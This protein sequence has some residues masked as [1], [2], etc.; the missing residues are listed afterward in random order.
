MKAKLSPWWYRKTKKEK[1]IYCCRR[2]RKYL[3]FTLEEGLKI[4]YLYEDYDTTVNIPAMN[5]CPWCGAKLIIQEMTVRE[6]S[7]RQHLI[8]KEAREKLEREKKKKAKKR[9]VRGGRKKK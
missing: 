4:H 2:S 9:T 5:Y 3:K 8:A 6:Q 7:R 1:D